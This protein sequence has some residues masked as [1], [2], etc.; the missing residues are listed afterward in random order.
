MYDIL[1][2]M[3]KAWDLTPTE[4]AMVKTS[5]EIYGNAF[6]QMIR[7]PDG[8]LTRTVLDPTRV[9]LDRGSAP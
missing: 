2:E 9:E 1:A 8:S 3:K 6:I 4:E 5:L 7:R